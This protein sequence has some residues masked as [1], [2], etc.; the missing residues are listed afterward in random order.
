MRAMKTMGIILFLALASACSNTA[1]GVKEDADNMAE[2][3]AE[4]AE[5]TGDAMSGAMETGQIKSAIIADSRVTASDINVDTDETT[6][7]VTLN[8]TVPN[9]AQRTI[10]GEI[11]TAKA[12]GYTVVNRLTVMP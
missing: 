2:S 11:A 8:G 5:K 12:V 1:D 9:E 4:S 10:A 3:T 7:T 6:K